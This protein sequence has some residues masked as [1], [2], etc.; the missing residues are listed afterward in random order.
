MPEEISFASARDPWIGRLER[1][2]AGR[3]ATAV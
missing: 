2:I 3:S 1:E